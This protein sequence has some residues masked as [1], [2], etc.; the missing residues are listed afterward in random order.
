MIKDQKSAMATDGILDK[1]MTVQSP[2]TLNN[3][4]GHPAEYGSTSATG[5]H[6]NNHAI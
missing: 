5:Y 4:D 6:G 2:I 1:S 3:P